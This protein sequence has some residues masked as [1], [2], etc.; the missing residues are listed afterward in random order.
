MPF[1]NDVIETNK[2]KLS[3]ERAERTVASTS[4]FLFEPD[5]VLESLAARIVGQPDA[6]S[7]LHDMLHVVKADF[8]STTRPRCVMLFV[9]STGVGKTEVVRLLSES[10]LGSQNALCRI[11]M[12]TLAQEHYSASLLGAPPGYVGSKENHSL[13]DADKVEGS[14]SRPGIVLFDELEKAHDAVNRALLNVMDNGE[15]T[16]STGTKSMD[17]RNAM[18]FMT[19][20]IGARELAAYRQSFTRG[21]RKLLARTPSRSK[22]KSI[23]QT[24]LEK[25]F[26][27]EF[28]NRID[29]IVYFNELDAQ[30]LD[31]LVEIELNDLKKRLSKRGLTFHITETAKQHLLEV[32]DTRYGARAL[33]RRVRKVLEPAL[34]RAMNKATDKTLFTASYENNTLSITAEKPTG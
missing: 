10:L 8:S 6:L 7:A 15:L 21:W 26:D 18:I 1:L 29:R 13:L 33:K 12:N 24:A 28:I 4:R 23:L 17:F 3:Q 11:D 30:W 20:N 5:A 19:S 27:P 16:L 34:A 22:E 32:Y 14:F 9:G 25:R 2:A 31:A